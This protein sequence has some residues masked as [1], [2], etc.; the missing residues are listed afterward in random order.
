[1]ALRQGLAEAQRLYAPWIESR[2]IPFMDN[3]ECHLK[4]AY[5]FA[6]A[7][8]YEGA[9]EAVARQC[10]IVRNGIEG[11]HGSLVQPGRGVFPGTPV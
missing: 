3:K 8:D 9:G 7:G 10:G 1:M 2:E 6:K 4:Q 5:D 11:G